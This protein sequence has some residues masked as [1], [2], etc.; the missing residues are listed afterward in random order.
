MQKYFTEIKKDE[1]D[2]IKTSSKDIDGIRK[3]FNKAQAELEKV[4]KYRKQLEDT[5]KLV[6]DDTKKRIEGLTK[7]LKELV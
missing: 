3:D 1:E 5:L 7:Q 4:Q 6:Q 2:I